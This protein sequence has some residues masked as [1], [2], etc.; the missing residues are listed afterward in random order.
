MRLAES[1]HEGCARCARS[2]V[3]NTTTGQLY[4]D[5]GGAAADRI[6]TV[7]RGSGL[8]ASHFWVI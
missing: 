4:Y 2:I 6:A 8:V 3:Y 1:G 5:A 7:T